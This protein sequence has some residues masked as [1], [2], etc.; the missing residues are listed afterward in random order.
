MLDT[1]ES[2]LYNKDVSRETSHEWGETT[3]NILKAGDKIR[4]GGLEW[5]V[6]RTNLVGVTLKRGNYFC[7]KTWAEIGV[8][9]VVEK[10]N[11]GTVIRPKGDLFSKI[12][13]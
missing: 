11:L 8:A 10:T 1:P 2:L 13:G 7:T 3:V 12:Y 9:H 6:K 5:E 4:I